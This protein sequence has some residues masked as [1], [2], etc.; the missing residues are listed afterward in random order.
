MSEAMVEA[1]RSRGLCFH[2]CSESLEV[3]QLVCQLARYW[4]RQ[5]IAN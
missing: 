2:S 1:R 4:A 3:S 5:E